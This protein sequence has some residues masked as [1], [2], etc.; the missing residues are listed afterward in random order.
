MARQEDGAMQGEIRDNPAFNRYE[1]EVDGGTAFASY[2]ADDKTVVITHTE[3]PRPL[4][5]KGFGDQ[6]VRGVLDEVRASGRKVV[7]R[8]GFVA[9]YIRRHPEYQDLLG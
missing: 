8:C 6:L 7:P 5:G 4:R 2:R 3:V 1:M 9:I